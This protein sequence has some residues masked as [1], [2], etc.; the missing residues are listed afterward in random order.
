MKNFKWT[1]TLTALITVLAFAL[2]TASCIGANDPELIGTAWLNE[3]EGEGVIAIKFIDENIAEWRSVSIA[4]LGQNSQDTY[5]FE[6]AFKNDK[7]TLYPITDD[8]AQSS[9]YKRKGRKTAETGSIWKAS[10][11]PGIINLISNDTA[12]VEYKFVKSTPNGVDWELNKLTNQC[13]C[14]G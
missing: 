9:N 10:L 14:Q 1:L 8:Q 13:N 11:E 2:G 5:Y 7:L 3:R 4:M 6:Y 12:R